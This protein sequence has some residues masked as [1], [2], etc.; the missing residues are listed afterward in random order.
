MAKDKVAVPNEAI[1]L[2]IL[3]EGDGVV[4]MENPEEVAREIAY[5]I[6][7]AETEDDIFDQGGATSARDV[8]SV[9]LMIKNVRWQTSRYE[10]GGPKVFALLNATRADNG[11]ELLITCGSRNVMAQLF[12]AGQLG[13]IPFEKPKKFQENMTAA[14]FGALWLVSA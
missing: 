2:A 11:E 5:R 13:L 1:E 10:E 4:P 9:P 8:L 14:G 7:G 6:L 3:G 12:R